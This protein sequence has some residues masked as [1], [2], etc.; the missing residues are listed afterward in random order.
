MS[1]KIMRKP[2]SWRGW[3][4]LALLLP[5]LL[6]LLPVWWIRGARARRIFRCELCRS[7]VPP[8]VA[9]RLSDRYRLPSLR[10]LAAVKQS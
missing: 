6:I 4:R 9:R 3:L 2:R 7:G 10:S 8:V 1:A 5:W